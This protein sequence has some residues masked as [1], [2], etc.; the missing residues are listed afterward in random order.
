MHSGL[1]PEHADKLSGFWYLPSG[2][3]RANSYQSFKLWS[4][5]DSAAVIAWIKQQQPNL[6]EAIRGECDPAEVVQ[7]VYEG[8]GIEQLANLLS[9]SDQTPDLK[10][11]NT[12]SNSVSS[13]QY[14]RFNGKAHGMP[15]I[16]TSVSD[17]IV[18][19]ES[20][21]ESPHE[22]L[23]SSS[24][25]PTKCMQINLSNIESTQDSMAHSVTHISFSGSPIDIVSV[26]E[27]NHGPEILVPP[28]NE[29]TARPVLVKTFVDGSHRFGSPSKSGTI[30]NRESH[31]SPMSGSS[32]K[33][34]HCRSPLNIAAALTEIQSCG[35][36]CDLKNCHSVP[37]HRDVPVPGTPP[38]VSSEPMVGVS[39]DA[40]HCSSDISLTFEHVSQTPD[41]K[42]LAVE[43]S[44]SDELT[45]EVIEQLKFGPI[46]RSAAS[47][48]SKTTAAGNL[49][50]SLTNKNSVNP[51]FS[52]NEDSKQHHGSVE[53]L[54]LPTE[55]HSSHAR[56]KCNSPNIRSPQLSCKLKTTSIFPDMTSPG[57]D[58]LSPT[59]DSNAKR[60]HT[61]A[62]GDGLNDAILVFP[63]IN[64]TSGSA[65]P[66]KCGRSSSNM[67]SPKISQS[68]RVTKVSLVN[69]ATSDTTT[70][71]P[72]LNSPPVAHNL[73]IENSSTD[74][75]SK[76]S[77]SNETCTA[78]ETPSSSTK[79]NS[80]SIASNESQQMSSLSGRNATPTSVQKNTNRSGKWIH[81]KSMGLLSDSSK[82]NST[83]QPSTS[84]SLPGSTRESTPSTR[85]S[86]RLR[87]SLE[88][89]KDVI[90][91]Q[92]NEIDI[93]GK[94]DT[95]GLVD[96]TQLLSTVAVDPQPHPLSSI[97]NS[98]ES[99]VRDKVDGRMDTGVSDAIVLDESPSES[100]HEAL[101]SSSTTP[102]KHS[103]S[104]G[105]TK[106]MQINLSNIESTQDS[107]AHSVTHISSS[108]SSF[109]IVSVVEL[110]HGPEILVPPDSELTARP[111]LVKTFVDGS[112]R[113]GSPSKSGTNADR[114]SHTSPVS[115]LPKKS[116]QCRSPVNSLNS[117]NK[118]LVLGSGLEV[119]SPRRV[120][121]SSANEKNSDSSGVSPSLLDDIL[122]VREPYS[123]RERRIRKQ[124]D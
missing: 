60:C 3:Q 15:N 118:R 119:Q 73:S 32:K 67:N 107:M 31:S 69:S 13:K 51:P 74:K 86:S 50:P 35:D 24:T 6:C 83:P 8:C 78:S 111:V 95:S 122:P 16:S 91:S 123:L 108:G 61:P 102:S 114:K 82:K 89:A 81:L 21:S 27:L 37:Y 48:E 110:N 84:R 9:L 53:K 17:A 92:M 106:S 99:L 112:H 18:L 28:D 39:L 56:A 40:T 57:S 14:N 96:A 97:H 42:I 72:L 29:L 59:M 80:R 44:M 38:S 62:A 94:H 90:S 101:G 104:E 55:L 52:E 103:D 93:D 71:S 20:P 105:S 43:T 30:A 115:G 75:S 23:G 113:F 41:Q 4:H 85:R 26:V 33:L 121:R 2:A 10:P 1:K 58:E 124:N 98:T 63:T 100:P 70:S 34:S 68:V 11:Q 22:A 116:L 120:L 49:S 25:T 77:I 87:S 79:R 36:T 117:L 45:P 109:D 12:S 76:A 54:G 64:D 19:D 5:I 88:E 46:D 7:S 65:T 66:I 47:T